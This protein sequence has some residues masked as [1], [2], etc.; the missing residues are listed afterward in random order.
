VNSFLGGDG[1]QGTLLSPE[2]EITHQHLNFLIGGGNHAGR[3]CLNLLVDGRVVRSATGD[4]SEHLTWKSWDVRELQGKR[5]TLEIVDRHGSGWGHIN[6][7]HIILAD[8]PARTATEPALWADYGRDFYAAVS[9]SDIPKRDGR[10]LWIGWMSNWEYAQDVPT[11]PWR[12]VMSLP[13]ELALHASP[14]GLRLVQRPV[15]ELQQLRGR[16]HRFRNA[17]VNDAN[18]WL[19]RLDS[20]GEL[21]EI[22]IEFVS[23]AKADNFDLRLRTGESEE[24]RVGCDLANGRLSLDRIRSGRVDFH[25]KFP[26]IHEAPLRPH[27]GLLKLHI[28]L[29]TSSIEVFANDGEPVLTGL[30]FP[31]RGDRRLELLSNADSLKVKALDVW[32]LK[33]GWR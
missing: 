5:A 14:D 13:R 22:V 17:T 23:A 8:A 24:T 30:I 7:D 9:W 1:A 16:H 10:R 31:S 21:L 12:S 6:V 25:P 2:F 19:Q 20:S 32:E 28:F 3:T 29:D 33:R 26:G 15:R 11:S 18:A 27:D 4:N